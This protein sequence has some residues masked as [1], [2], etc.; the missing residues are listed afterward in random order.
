MGV[1]IFEWNKIVI[2]PNLTSMF[3]K[4]NSTSREHYRTID[5]ITLFRDN[6]S[7][8][9]KCQNIVEA[10]EHNVLTF[11]VEIVLYYFE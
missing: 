1:K 4:T 3:F 7:N 8:F 10:F 6:F 11:E 2:N 5:K 9:W